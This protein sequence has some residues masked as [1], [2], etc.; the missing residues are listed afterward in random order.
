MIFQGFAN[1]A[2]R[3]HSS[4]RFSHSLNNIHVYE[5]PIV[6]TATVDYSA[7]NEYANAHYNI[8]RYFD[9]DNEVIFAVD[10]PIYDGR[11]L[12]SKY[13]D[14]REMLSENGLAVINSPIRMQ[15]IDWSNV[16]DVRESYLPEL[17]W[18]LVHNLFPSRRIL[19]C[20]FWNPMLRGEGL[21]ISRNEGGMSTA[22]IASLV[23]I[24][25]DVGAYESIDELLNVIDKNK[26]E[27]T[28][29]ALIDA[30][31]MASDNEKKRF[32]II[33]FWRNIDDEPVLSS[34]LAILST[35][36]NEDEHQHLW[37]GLPNARP[38]MEKSRY[39]VFPQA[40]DD[41]VIAF[42][43]YDRNAMQVSDM[44]HC[45]I[46]PQQHGVGHEASTRPRRSFD[47]RALVVFDENVPE[48]LDRF[49]LNRIRPKLTMEESECFCEKQGE[50]RRK[51]DEIIFKT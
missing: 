12:Q 35:R 27:Y 26:V 13:L 30:F 24:D 5:I 11:V 4:R 18:I 17:E 40:T 39:Y 2:A 8:P 50:D 23:H 6:C 34:P 36:Y 44:W 38:N 41:E 22:N 9:Y 14:E 42:Y 29:T 1:I 46:K 32:V 15:T 51:Q 31:D 48:E 28:S 33:N 43:Q 45:A 7:A 49:G 21:E 19:S 37:S 25:T 20:C 3:P 47:I 10:H 16:D